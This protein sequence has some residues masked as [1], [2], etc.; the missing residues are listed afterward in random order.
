MKSSVYD[1]KFGVCLQTLLAHVPIDW[2]SFQMT[3]HQLHIRSSAQRCRESS[4][5]PPTSQRDWCW[6]DIMSMFMEQNYISFNRS[7]GAILNWTDRQWHTMAELVN[8]HLLPQ[9]GAPMTLQALQAPYRS[10]SQTLKWNSFPWRHWGKKG[11]LSLMSVIVTWTSMVAFRGGEPW[12]VA[13]TV[14]WW[15]PW[16]SRSN[17]NQLISSP[18]KTAKRDR[19]CARILA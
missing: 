18:G 14:M 19:H 8:S 1:Y 4:R 15:C 11:L 13:R 6:G 9:G 5:I 7:G 3:V 10:T 16:C 12:S 17:A 2:H